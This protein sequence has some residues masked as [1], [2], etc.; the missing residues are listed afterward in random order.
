MKNT[1]KALALTSALAMWSFQQAGAIVPGVTAVN[2]GTAN[3]PTT[4]GGLYTMSAYDPG[5]IGGQS[6]YEHMVNGNGEGA[7][8]PGEGQWSTWGQNYSGNVYVS[9][10]TAGGAS[11]LTLNLSGAAE[12]VYFYEEPNQFQDFDMTATDSSGATVTTTINGYY[13]SAGIG[14]YED[15]PG[16]AYLTSI[17][18]TATDPTGFAIGEFG[19]S[20]GTLTGTTGVPDGGA[21]AL[22]MALGLGGLFALKRFGRAVA[23]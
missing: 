23:V 18:V 5:S 20:G 13:G 16:G 2:L 12:A 10:T 3:P 4:L 19:L 8:H 14:F 21:T 17:T 11:A 9:Y 6:Y 15:V 7:L 22:L 1:I